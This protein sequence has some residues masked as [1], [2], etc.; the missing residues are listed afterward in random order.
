MSRIP[1]RVSTVIMML[2]A[3]GRAFAEDAEGGRAAAFRAV[4]G[5][6]AEQVP[7]GPLLIVA[8]AIVWALIFLYLFRLG[9]LQTH[10]L[11]EIEKLEKRLG[12]RASSG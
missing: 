4:T 5:P 8:Y 6:Q 12:N 10:T 2:C 1:A 9:R 11:E 7:G 3:T